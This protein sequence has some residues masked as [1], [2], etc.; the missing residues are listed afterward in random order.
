[1]T[2]IYLVLLRTQWTHRYGD[3][4]VLAAYFSKTEAEEWRKNEA[5][6]RGQ[7]YQLDDMYIEEMNVL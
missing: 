3:G 5:K 2:T 6:P 4:P 1:M 7:G